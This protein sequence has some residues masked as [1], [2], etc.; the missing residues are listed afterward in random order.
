MASSEYVRQRPLT[1]AQQG[2]FLKLVFPDFR[3]IAARHPLLW[4]GTLQP[5]P[6]SDKYTHAHTHNRTPTRKN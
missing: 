2:Y 1:P 4:R 5:S 6:A 3:V